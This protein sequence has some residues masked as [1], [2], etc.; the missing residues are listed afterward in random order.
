MEIVLGR[1]QLLSHI[2]ITIIIDQQ[3]IDP[4]TNNKIKK[5]ILM[6]WALII[7]FNKYP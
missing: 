5:V 1:P 6:L 4:V 3:I 2:S 7:I